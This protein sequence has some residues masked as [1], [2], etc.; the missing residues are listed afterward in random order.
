MCRFVLLLT[1]LGYV[2]MYTNC[3]PLRWCIFAV[4][5]FLLLQNVVIIRLSICVH[6]DLFQ[7]NKSLCYKLNAARMRKILTYYKYVWCI[8]TFKKAPLKLKIILDFVFVKI[9][10]GGS[11]FL[12]MYI[13]VTLYNVRTVHVLFICIIHVYIYID[14]MEDAYNLCLYSTIILDLWVWHT[15]LVQLWDLCYALQHTVYVCIFYY[16]RFVCYLTYFFK[17]VHPEMV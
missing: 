12:F 14:M 10:K 16:E 11:I 4:A 8:P 15:P 3:K 2:P 1:I 9:F 5:V 7:T 6:F 17:F 13:F